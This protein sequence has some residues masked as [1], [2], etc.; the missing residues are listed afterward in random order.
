MLEF[1]ID[2]IDCSH[3]ARFWAAFRALVHHCGWVFLRKDVCLVCDRPTKYAFDA[4]GNYHGFVEPAIAYADGFS[5]YVHH[6][7]V[8]PERDGTVLPSQWQARWLVTE[9]NSQLR[10]LLIQEIGYERICREL[11]ARSLSTWREYELLSIRLAHRESLNLLKMT[12][13][14]TGHLHFL[15]VPPNLRSAREAIRW[16]NWGIDP[17]EFTVQT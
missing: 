3:N 16:V 15:V 1:S 14:S 7:T 10:R 9:S 2:E 6:G 4:Q 17:D 5:V 8:L 13:P 11:D 12:C